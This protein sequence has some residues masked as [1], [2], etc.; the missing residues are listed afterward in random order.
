ML[1]YAWIVIRTLPFRKVMALVREPHPSRPVRD[2]DQVAVSLWAVRAVSRRLPW[3]SVCFDRAIA[4]HLMLRRRSIP[5]T[6][7][8]GVRMGNEDLA[9]HVWLSTDGR[10]ILGAREAEGFTC[11][12]TYPPPAA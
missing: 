10:A 4:L 8:Y 7:H 5:S 11:L 3:R 9:A 6:L 12:A 2:E 1:S